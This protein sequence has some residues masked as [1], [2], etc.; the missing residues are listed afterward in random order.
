M[1]RR[2][3]RECIRGL[4]QRKG[5]GGTVTI[6]G[7]TFKENVPD[8]RNSRVTDIVRELLAF[9]ITVQIADPLADADAVAEEYGMTLTELGALQPA[10]AVILAVAHDRY[11]E[12][13]WSLIQMLLGEGTGLVL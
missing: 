8:T 5:R 2:I 12:G 10:D 13:R 1:G 6:L 9:G 11:V 3:A 4:L 7:M